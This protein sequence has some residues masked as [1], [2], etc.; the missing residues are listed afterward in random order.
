M[1]DVPVE[2]GLQAASPAL[3]TFAFSIS[4]ANAAQIMTILANSLYSDKPLSVLREYASNAHD[5]HIQAG[6]PDTPI[7]IHLPTPDEPFLSIRDFGRGLSHDR[8]RTF[9]SFGD[10]DKR[11]SD[12]VVGAYGIG[13]KS[14]FAYTDSFTVT[15]FHDGMKRL[16]SAVKTA[17]G[18]EMR[19]L[20]E[21]PTT[22]TGLLVEGAVKH[23]DVFTF[24]NTAFQVLRGFEPKPILNIDARYPV[25]PRTLY[26]G[27]EGYICAGG[28]SWEVQMGCIIYPIDMNQLKL[29]HFNSLHGRVI[30]P[31]GSV[32][33]AAS[34]ETLEYT[35]LTK[36]NIINVM[37][38]LLV[39]ATRVAVASVNDDTLSSWE[40]RLKAR[41]AMRLNNKAHLFV[42]DSDLLDTEVRLVERSDAVATGTVAPKPI[43]TFTA[44][45]CPVHDSV[46]FV[47][48][49]GDTRPFTTY[50]S[51]VLVRTENKFSKLADWEDF[52]AFLEKTKLTGVNV[53]FLTNITRKP[54]KVTAKREKAQ[55]PYHFAVFSG[56][57]FC[58]STTEPS[59]DDLHIISMTTQKQEAR[60]RKRENLVWLE[61]QIRDLHAMAAKLGVPFPRV[62]RYNKQPYCDLPAAFLG[63]PFS[64]DA[65]VDRLFEAIPKDVL[66]SVISCEI[67]SARSVYNSDGAVKLSKALGMPLPSKQAFELREKLPHR[68]E[69]KIQEAARSERTLILKKYPLLAYAHSG[70]FDDAL[71]P[72]LDYIDLIN[73][74]QTQQQQQTKDAAA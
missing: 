41:E 70:G 2:Q 55:V 37:E 23:K 9:V 33:V 12:D 43:F 64:Q 15:S 72:F 61:R 67:W 29:P 60:G 32:R 31:I 28:G 17:K 62:V 54:V 65:L 4:T 11:D 63:S 39:E 73:A 50:S 71:K 10:S 40:R 57:S 26:D 5:E 16:Y 53:E 6:I 47:L 1:R 58:T 66:Q 25:K 18:G 51:D 49:N 19:L 21:E 24:Q 35:D 36:T 59:A 46:R 3:D 20:H 74:Q 34:R 44:N 14:F 30:V 13:C 68:I 8:M 38:D 22:E 42:N 69:I 56:H 48:V 45:T 52:K 27:K 7:S